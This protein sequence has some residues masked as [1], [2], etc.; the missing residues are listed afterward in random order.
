MKRG[1]IFSLRDRQI[2]VS[3]EKARPYL[4]PLVYFMSTWVSKS[5]EDNRK[6]S[7]E[8]FSVGTEYNRRQALNWSRKFSEV[9]TWIDA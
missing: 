5:D 3:G 4:E 1:G 8:R 7:E 2:V 9:L 6:K